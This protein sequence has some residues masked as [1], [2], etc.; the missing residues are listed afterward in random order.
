M[1]TARPCV[2]V[3]EDDDDVR[4]SVAEAVG[5]AG[6]EVVTARHGGEALA[7]LQDASR[8]PA[9]MLLDLMM[10]VVDGWGVLARL[11]QGRVDVPVV[12]M[13][14][15]R[16]PRLPASV[17]VLPKPFGADAVLAAIAARCAD[18]A[19]K[20]EL[21]LYV[22]DGCP[23]SERA[24]ETLAGVLDGYRPEAIKL[25]VH[26]V[27]RIDP[28]QLAADGVVVAPTLL[29]HRPLRLRFAGSFADRRWLRTVLGIVEVERRERPWRVR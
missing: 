20:I 6:Y 4:D 2:L 10:P 21:S 27:A 18:R 23:A 9:V 19:P 25:V 15:C 8:R 16:D 29:M 13:T 28:A 14:A 24:I 5:L 12:V 11:A 22:A 3:V 17:P 1:G 26:N 7:I